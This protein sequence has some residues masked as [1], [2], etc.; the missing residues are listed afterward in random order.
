[1]LIQKYKESPG[2]SEVAMTLHQAFEWGINKKKARWKK[3][4]GQDFAGIFKLFYEVAGEMEILH[5]SVRLVKR[6]TMREVLDRMRDKRSS[7]DHTYLKYKR[8]T[9]NIFQVL[10]GWEHIDFNPCD[11]DSDVKK[12]KP[13]EKQLLTPDQQIK[14]KKQILE[15]APALWPYLMIVNMTSIRPGEILSIRVGSINLSQQTILLRAADTKDDEDRLVIIPNVLVPHIAKL[16]LSNYPDHYFVF[17]TGF[18][19]Q[20]RE[21]QVHCNRATELWKELVKDPKSKGGLGIQS[22][23][24]WLKD[25][26]ISAS[27]D[28]DIDLEAIQQQA[29]HSSIEMT[30]KY[31][32]KNR[33]KTIKAIREK[34]PDIWK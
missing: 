6:S 24:Y 32:Q 11:W 2:Q 25:L 7:G 30:M 33:P 20:E 29:G 19:P 10:V 15:K 14:V 8:T 21:S 17:G 31:V 34:T 23:M 27:I 4:S 28:E 16:N 12:P 5:K 3:K 13:K 22:N 9:H 1:M 18:L 26:G